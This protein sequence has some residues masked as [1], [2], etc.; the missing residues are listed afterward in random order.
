VDDQL[1]GYEATVHLIRLGC[2]ELVHLTAQRNWTSC[3]ARRN[4]FEMAA[5]RLGAGILARTCELEYCSTPDQ[6]RTVVRQ[7]LPEI[8]ATSKRRLGIFALHD[9]LA[10]EVLSCVRD[11]GGAVPEEVAIVGFDNDIEGALADVPLTTVEIPREEIAARAVELLF[12]QINGER[13]APVRLKLKPRLVIRQSCGCYPVAA[14][15]I[16]D[17]EVIRLGRAL[18]AH[19]QKQGT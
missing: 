9:L 4:G 5:S 3:R 19:S 18:Q 13:R 15:S 16:R 10:V 12:S 2:A 6:L 8:L 17:E 11:L 1:G 14:H 7:A